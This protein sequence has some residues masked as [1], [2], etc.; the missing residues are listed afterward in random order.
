M[1]WFSTP[2][3]CRT[4]WGRFA[5]ALCGAQALLAQ[6]PVATGEFTLYVSNEASGDVSII[7][8][9]S[10]TPL[11]TLAVGQRPR[12]IHLSA[13]GHTLYVATSGS[14]RLGPGADPDRANAQA[15]KSAD[16]IAI[17]DLAT[18]RVTR[19]L[20]VGSDPE[21]F[22]LTPD[23]TRL[24]VSNED[25]STAS[26]WDIASGRRIFAAK[27][28][29]EPEGVALHPTA[30]EV[31]ITCEARGDVFVLDSGNG[32]EIARLHVRGRPRSVAFLSSRARAYIPAEGEAEVTVVDTAQ[33]RIVATIQI[34]GQDI[35]P[36]GA[37]S[38]HD[39]REVFVSTGRG[40]TVAVIDTD[41]NRVTAM[42]R[43]GERPWGIALSPD[44]TKLYTANGLS[45][46]LSVIDVATH[47]EI[48]RVKTGTRPWGIAVGPK[49][50][51]DQNR[52]A[53]TGKK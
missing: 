35:F 7:D 47:R 17:I 43:V 8:G 26:A 21:Q 32:R 4:A 15:D 18:R 44:G 46:D 27:V 13:D 41:T 42:I 53:P 25:E 12:G 36:M 30:P 51:S 23:G 20:A 40:N 37:V 9:R 22:A 5:L 6:T 2:N 24:I 49:L 16:G 28:T 33:H 10:Q 1:R 29:E 45:D 34:A 50:T 52:P 11:A 14:P 39:G 3:R 38:S 19:R 31:Y 48:A